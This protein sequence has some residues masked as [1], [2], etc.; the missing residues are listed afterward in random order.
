MNIEDVVESVAGCAGITKH[1]ARRS[2]DCY[3]DAIQG[4]L[5]KGEKVALVGFGTFQVQKRKVCKGVNP[6]TGERISIP[7]KYV[8]EFKPGR[9]LRDAVE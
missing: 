1:Q 6:Q 9:N 2:I 7:A 4:A 3:H 5:A 8:P